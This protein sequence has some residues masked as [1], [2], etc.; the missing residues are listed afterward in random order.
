LHGLLRKSISFKFDENCKDA[1]T[2]LKT[3]VMCAD[4][5]IC[6]WYALHIHFIFGVGCFV[7][8]QLGWQNRLYPHW[9]HWE[10][11]IW[12]I[13]LR[14]LLYFEHI[15]YC[16]CCNNLQSNGYVQIVV[17][18]NVLYFYSIAFIAINL[19]HVITKCWKKHKREIT[20]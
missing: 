16:K 10:L 9:M 1:F 19:L 13:L 18:S 7:V 4:V 17:E 15:N 11:Y 8:V 12:L 5:S 20:S 3:A 6:L 14:R 2:I